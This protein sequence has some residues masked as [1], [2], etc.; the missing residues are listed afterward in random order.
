MIQPVELP[1]TEDDSNEPAATSPRSRRLED[2]LDSLTS[3]IAIADTGS[4]SIEY[5]NGRFQDWFP[6]SSTSLE[7]RVPDFDRGRAQA[8]LSKGRPYRWEAEV[9]TGVRTVNV[10]IEI[11]LDTI[12]RDERAVI[13]VTNIAKQK[14]AEYMLDSYS[15]LVERQTRELQQEKERAEK[16]L[17]NIMPRRVYEELN[18]YGTTTPQAF[19]EVSVLLLDFAGF[20]E[21]AIAQEPTA[22]IAELND[23]FT[24]FDRIVEHHRCERI[25]TIGDAYMAVSGIPDP[26][27]DHAT[28]MARVAL[29]MSRFLERRNANSPT[30]WHARIGI[31]CGKA[32][33]SIVG[34][35]KYVYDI[36]GPAVNLA[37]RLEQ[38]AEPMQILICPATAECV[39]NDFI[40]G[41]AGTAEL[42]GFG[43]LPLYVL[44]DEA[45]RGR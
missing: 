21:M 3:A 15:R 44:Q 20:T 1:R 9:R 43:K 8:R 7:S 33:G 32:I 11:R 12:D 13:E 26:D 35:Q 23:I 40:L 27:P 36:F 6:G 17:L 28:N 45:R 34:V 41:D 14:E 10:Q 25:K 29:R 42:R 4:F 30:Q 22:L 19:D 16:L 31:G 5:A 38:Q 39:R 18:D 2:T 37:Y 24:S